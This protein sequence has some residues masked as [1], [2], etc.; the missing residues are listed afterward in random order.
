MVTV[1]DTMFADVPTIT[2]DEAMEEKIQLPFVRLHH[3]TTN[4]ELWCSWEQ[5]VFAFHYP[6][7][8]NAFQLPPLEV[9][10]CPVK[11]FYFNE[12]LEAVYRQPSSCHVVMSSDDRCPDAVQFGGSSTYH[13]VTYLQNRRSLNR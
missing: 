12:R 3:Q 6:G 7:T 2:Q 8:D 10:I 4:K 1:N 11:H 13:L 5:T 9:A